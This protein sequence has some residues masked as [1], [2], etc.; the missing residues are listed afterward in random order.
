MKGRSLY[1][2]WAS[3][4]TRTDGCWLWT[5]ST[6]KNG[7]GNLMGTD[8]RNQYAHRVAHVLFI[9]PIPEG[10]EVDHLCRVR[11]CVK[12]AHLEAVTRQENLRRRWEGRRKAQTPAGS[13]N[14][15][16]DSAA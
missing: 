5:G 13:E 11:N 4:V 1:E 2:R 12:P 14:P 3:K 7:Y 10:Y 8:G 6:L 9:G 15:R 16:S